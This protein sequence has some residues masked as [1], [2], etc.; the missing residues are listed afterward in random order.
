MKKDGKISVK[1]KK[2][3]SIPISQPLKFRTRN[4]NTGC[5]GANAIGKI[6]GKDKFLLCLFALHNV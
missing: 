5:T 4:A 2:N 6:R 1:R 3:N